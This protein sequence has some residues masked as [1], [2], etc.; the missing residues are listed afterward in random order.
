MASSSMFVD[1]AWVGSA[2][3]AGVA[4]VGVAT[5]GAAV[6]AT[7]ELA[8][9]V[10]GEGR[11]KFVN[12]VLRKASDLDLPDT[13]GVRTSHPDWLVERCGDLL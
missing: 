1:G 3:G 4:T 5:V 2:S 10:L 8:R 12:A 9:A 11:S 7:V 6:S 13:I